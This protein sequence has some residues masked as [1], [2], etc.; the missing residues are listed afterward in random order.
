MPPTTT[1]PD[2]ELARLAEAL[3]AARKRLGIVA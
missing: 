1:S 3:V 2:E